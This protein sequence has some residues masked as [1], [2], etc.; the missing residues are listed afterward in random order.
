MDINNKRFTNDKLFYDD[1]N[2]KL[3]TEPFFIKCTNGNTILE[4]PEIRYNK[5]INHINECEKNNNLCFI[6]LQIH[7]WEYD[8]LIPHFDLLIN[9]KKLNHDIRCRFKNYAI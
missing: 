2:I 4:I 3:G 9:I 1:T 7:H 8:K 5:V 6:K